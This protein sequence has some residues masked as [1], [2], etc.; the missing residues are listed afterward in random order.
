LSVLIVLIFVIRV[1]DLVYEETKVNIIGLNWRTVMR[2][3]YFNAK[4]I[5]LPVLIGL[6]L[7]LA[8]CQ[9]VVS[10]AVVNES[11]DRIQVRFVM[12]K[13]VSGT[14]DT[15]PK[16]LGIKALSELSDLNKPWG[17]LQGAQIAFQPETRTVVVSLMP[18]EALRVEE[19]WNVR[20]TDTNPVRQSDYAIEEISVTGANGAMKFEGEQALRGFAQGP[21][22]VCVLTY[23]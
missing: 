1:T 18:R 6:V 14:S 16:E 2:S 15:P 19:L 9:S 3:R 20:C 23:H 13:P 22:G 21:K 12:K 10:Y 7:T 17:G 5:L 4:L 11:N 8:G